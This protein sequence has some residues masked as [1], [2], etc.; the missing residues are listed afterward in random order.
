M[1]WVFLGISIGLRPREI[2]SKTHASLAKMR[3]VL[4]SLFNSVFELV[5]RFVS[6]SRVANK[7]KLRLLNVLN[8][9]G[10][11]RLGGWHCHCPALSVLC[12][13]NCGLRRAMTY[14]VAL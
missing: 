10:W 13:E 14:D 8:G 1:A 7:D 5:P 11:V 2:P 3:R 6:P 9:W 12:G 4:Q